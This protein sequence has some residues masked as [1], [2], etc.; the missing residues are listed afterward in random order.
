VLCRG[1]Y[2]ILIIHQMMKKGV[3]ASKALLSSLH[4]ISSSSSQKGSEDRDAQISMYTIR[5]TKPTTKYDCAKQNELSSPYPGSWFSQANQKGRNLSNNK[6]QMSYVKC[7]I[8]PYR[9]FCF[10]SGWMSTNRL[11]EHGRVVSEIVKHRGLK[12]E[13][14]E[15]GLAKEEYWDTLFFE[16]SKKS[17]HG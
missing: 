8:S 14:S 12:P 10:L 1:Y 15:W 9:E 13:K 3:Q 11:C 7:Q 4:S 2:K 6:C 5:R 16:L 17:R